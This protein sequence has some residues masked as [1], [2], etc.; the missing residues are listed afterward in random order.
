MQD[1]VVIKGDGIGPEIT[2][3]TLR[4]LD[5]SGAEFNPV[6]AIAGLAAYEAGVKN[7]LPAETLRHLQDIGVALKAPLAT[8][9]G[10]GYRSVNVGIRGALS[11]FANYRPIRELPNMPNRFAGAGVDF[12]LMREN[13]EDLY[14][15]QE[16][17]LSPDVAVAMK[18]ISDLASERIIRAAFEV[19]RLEGRSTV[20]L[21]HKGNILQLTE[22][23]FA[24]MLAKVSRDYPAIGAET[25]IVDNL[26]EKLITNPQKFQVVVMTNMNGDILSDEGAGIL[27]SLGLAPSANLGRNAAMFEAVHGTAP[28]I[29]GKN[30]ANPTAMILSAELM[31]RHIGQTDAAVRLWNAVMTTL[32]KGEK[33]TGDV[34]TPTSIKV[35]TDEFADEIIKNMGKM[36]ENPKFQHVIGTELP[37]LSQIKLTQRTISKSERLLG[38]DVMIASDAKPEDIAE[39]FKRLKDPSVDLEFIAER[40]QVVYPSSIKHD[41]SSGVLTLRLIGKEGAA[42]SNQE[43]GRTLSRLSTYFNIRSSSALLEIDGKKSYSELSGA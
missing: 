36:P 1:I 32:E 40:G 14:I 4:V 10:G 2:D 6:P 11:L 15:G 23:K 42:I 5:A 21:A 17:K 16:Y 3:A 7:G 26:A 25:I 35:G 31:L 18:V 24:D 30:W 43:M 12:V 19:A 39:K 20:H 13:S 33:R 22:G 29:A 38:L 41:E 37:D 27:G 28:D 8:P 9:T 34:M